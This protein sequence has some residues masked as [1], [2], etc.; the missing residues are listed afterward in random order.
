MAPARAVECC[1][2]EPEAL[3]VDFCR[4]HAAISSATPA[5]ASASF[6]ATL[7]YPSTTWSSPSPGR[8]T[9][10]D[11]AVCLFITLPLTSP[12]QEDAYRLT[13]GRTTTVPR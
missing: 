6:T 5:V 11:R 13:R 8:E 9:P 10:Y 3:R 12:C 4:R 2:P 7:S 1:V